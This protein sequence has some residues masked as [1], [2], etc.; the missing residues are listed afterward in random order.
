M[1]KRNTGVG[2]RSK[3]LAS[4]IVETNDDISRVYHDS[5]VMNAH[6]LIHLSKSQWKRL[7]PNS[8]H[9]TD[10]NQEKGLC[11]YSNVHFGKHINKNS[12]Q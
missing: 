4:K 6:S 2:K 7:E 12:Y 10:K 11:K 3:I 9:L 8:I 1:R 5:S